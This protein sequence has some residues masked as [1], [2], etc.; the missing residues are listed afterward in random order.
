MKNTLADDLRQAD[1]RPSFTSRQRIIL[2][3]ACSAIFFEA[4]DVSIVNLALPVIA[5]DL[6]IS[7]AATQWVQTLYILSFG[8]FLILGGRLCDHFGSRSIFM[9][10]MFLFGAASA[11]ALFSHQL[12]LLLAARS[13]QGIGASLAMPGG[14]SLLGRHFREGSQRQSAIGIFGSFAAVGFAGGLALGG[15]IASFFDWHWIFGLNVPV[16]ALVLVA[17]R[18]YIPKEPLQPTGPFNLLTACWL[19]ATLLLFCYGIHEMTRLGWWDLPCLLAALLSGYGLY[20]YDQRQQQPFFAR[21]IYSSSLAYRSLAASLIMGAT[22]LSFIFLSTLSLYELL[23]WNIRSTGLLLFPFSIGS[24]LVSK[25]LLPRLFQRLQVVEVGMLSLLWLLTGILL[26]IVGIKAQHLL[27]FLPAFLLVNSLSIAIGYP[28]FTIL[29]LTGV[30]PAR[31]GIA[32][33]L[34]SAIY[35]VGTGIGLSLT[36]LCLQ[37]FPGRTMGF[38]LLVAAL[39]L[40]ALCG[41]ALIL[42]D[43]GRRKE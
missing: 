23:G 24:A 43:G 40:A 7:L 25:F 2:W 41:L 36:G 18:L 16:I 35:S 5:A 42:L 33:G 3:L 22:F 38:R 12:P 13:A 32:A 4:F 10:G 27:F 20:R 31:Q 6:R 34:Q 19:T 15:M 11:I 14:I 39:P 30:P 21:D 1:D 29:S 9:T 28:S 37:L 26:M 8:G 17:A